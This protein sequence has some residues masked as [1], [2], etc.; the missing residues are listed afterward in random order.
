MT[1]KKRLPNKKQKLW[2][3]SPIHNLGMEDHSYASCKEYLDDAFE[4][5]DIHNLALSGNFGAGKSSILH[6]FDR[7]R[8]YGEEKFLYVSLT[9]FQNYGCNCQTDNTNICKN[10]HKKDN[11]TEQ[12]NSDKEVNDNSTQKRVEFSMLCQI[13]S[14]CRK[15][16]LRDSSL[17]GIPEAAITFVGMLFSALFVAL[18]FVLVFHERFA[19]LAARVGVSAIL[20]ADIHAWMYVA[21]ACLLCFLVCHILRNGKVKKI[22]VKSAYAETEMELF[23]SSASLDL[24]KFE[25]IHTII[26]LAPSIDHT[27]VFEDMDRLDSTICIAVITKLR[28]LNVMINTRRQTALPKSARV[29]LWLWECFENGRF[30]SWSKRIIGRACPRW[31]KKWLDNHY[32]YLAKGTTHIR[33]V[34][35]VGENVLNHQLRSKFYDCIIPVTPALNQF[36]AEDV[37]C[38]LLVD[39]GVDITREHTWKN[40]KEIIPFLSDYRTV[41]TMCN[42]FRVLRSQFLGGVADIDLNCAQMLGMAF[43]KVMVPQMYSRAFDEDGFGELPEVSAAD[44]PELKDQEYCNRLA[45]QLNKIRPTKDMLQLMFLSRQN[46]CS[47]WIRALQEGPQERAYDTI[48]EMNNNE[49]INITEELKESKIFECGVDSS[50]VTSVASY[51]FQG[52]T[53]KE[54]FDA[55][56]Y[57]TGKVSEH[58]FTNCMIFLTATGQLEIT[59]V[60]PAISPAEL[61]GWCIDSL[62]SLRNDSGHEARWNNEMTGL[63]ET[64]LSTNPTAIPDNLLDIRITENQTLED[65]VSIDLNEL[66]EEASGAVVAEIEMLKVINDFRFK[67]NQDPK[68]YISRNE[69]VDFCKTVFVSTDSDAKAELAEHIAQADS[70]DISKE[71]IEW[72]AVEKSDNQEVAF[73]LI[74]HIQKRIEEEAFKDW[75]FKISEPRFEKFAKCMYWAVIRYSYFAVEQLF[76]WCL[77]NLA[78]L[79]NISEH[80]SCWCYDNTWLLREVLKVSPERVQDKMKTIVLYDGITIGDLLSNDDPFAEEDDT[81]EESFEQSHIELLDTE[82]VGS[83]TYI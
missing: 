29:Q 48:R 11:V 52:D 81:A 41:R 58:K 30:L 83:G 32:P 12:E 37:L 40:I 14:R 3:L 60:I 72:Q 70:L 15:K 16:N 46:L 38:K 51:I 59:T 36:N 6:S 20:R 24:Y 78:V 19:Y 9:D 27:V 23:K 44:F 82:P 22:S 61:F 50:L 79:Q 49:L 64:I 13:L 7:N 33:F 76:D 63:L 65:L 4:N 66:D 17:S 8:N 5:Q 10:S 35:A 2:P 53:S 69:F 21:T 18:I 28:D 55:W 62:P 42:E 43:Y 26:D 47:R 39:N 67:S 31:V 73:Y 68:R 56:F 45:N 77:E 54:S 25:L 74:R 34:Y 80:Q 75:F 1:Q 71:L 57:K